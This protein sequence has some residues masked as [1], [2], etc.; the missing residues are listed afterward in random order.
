[1]QLRRRNVDLAHKSGD[2]EFILYVIYGDALVE[3]VA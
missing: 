2:M 3:G 1:M